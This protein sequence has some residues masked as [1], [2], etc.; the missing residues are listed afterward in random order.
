MV[1]E[2]VHA[3]VTLGLVFHGHEGDL[4]YA[5]VDLAVDSALAGEK[6]HAKSTGGFDTVVAA[7]RTWIP[8]EWQPKTS[9]RTARS[10]PHAELQALD[11]GTFNSG[12]PMAHLMEQALRRQVVMV[13]REGNA[14]T[15]LAVQRGYSKKLS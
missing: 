5:L 14:T 9:A 2:Y 10:T 4:P 7:P 13:G 11:V 12:N 8:A 1:K 3:T 15:F 6:D